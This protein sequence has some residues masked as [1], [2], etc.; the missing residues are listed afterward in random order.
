MG[1]IESRRPAQDARKKAVAGS[2]GKPKVFT[3]ADV[4]NLVKSPLFR[5]KR[6]GFLS[7]MNT[8]VTATKTALHRKQKA[9]PSATLSKI[10]GLMKPLLEDTCEMEQCST[11][12]RT[13]GLSLP[14]ATNEVTSFLYDILKQKKEIKRLLHDNQVERLYKFLA[15]PT[16][17]KELVEGLDKQNNEAFVIAVKNLEK[18]HGEILAVIQEVAQFIKRLLNMSLDLLMCCGNAHGKAREQVRFI[19]SALTDFLQGIASFSSDLNKDQ[20]FG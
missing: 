6:E 17:P 20:L 15:E 14:A 13:I 19:H 10:E 7:Q 16:F 12:L 18:L 5:K 3:A 2:G 9:I 11:S 1:N 4:R 8:L